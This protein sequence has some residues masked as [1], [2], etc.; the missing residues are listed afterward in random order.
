M[1]ICSTNPNDILRGPLVTG[2]QKLTLLLH[3]I[4]GTIYESTGFE[5]YQTKDWTFGS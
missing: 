3:N 1:P 2:E 4:H 5:K